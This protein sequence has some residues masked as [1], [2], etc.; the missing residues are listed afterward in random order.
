MASKLSLTQVVRH[1]PEPRRTRLLQ[2]LEQN[3]SAVMLT[4]KPA[5]DCPEG[6]RKRYGVRYGVPAQVVYFEAGKTRAVTIGLAVLILRLFRPN[7]SAKSG[8]LWQEGEWEEAGDL[9]LGTL[10]L[11]RAA[12]RE[13][14][15]VDAVEP[16]QRAP[17][18]SRGP[19]DDR[20]RTRAPDEGDVHNEPPEPRGASGAHGEGTE[21]LEEGEGAP[22][23][24]RAPAAGAKPLPQLSRAELATVHEAEVGP[25]PEGAKR[26][27]LLAAIGAK[28]RV[29]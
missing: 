14:E 2:A 17:L 28:R 20:P 22:A 19:T 5:P 26:T 7:P 23:R 27:D 10:D 16:V 6:R 8:A 4:Y 21:S 15:Q 9:D 13:R 12:R 25:V 1:E 18:P 24:S 11:T 29:G 3:G